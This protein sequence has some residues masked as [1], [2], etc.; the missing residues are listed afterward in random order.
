MT[1]YR[2]CKKD[3]FY[4]FVGPNLSAGTLHCLLPCTIFSVLLLSLAF[5]LFF[6]RICSGRSF[7]LSLI[8]LLVSNVIILQSA[9]TARIYRNFE[10][11]FI[12]AESVSF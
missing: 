6:F 10:Y 3:I 9:L 8:K 4:L 2:E 7:Y 12:L 11:E 1:I 5:F